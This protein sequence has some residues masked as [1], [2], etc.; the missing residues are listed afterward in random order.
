MG[1]ALGAITTSTSP[2]ATSLGAGVSS[3]GSEWSASATG[4]SASAGASASGVEPSC[5]AVS[6]GASA[7]ASCAGSSAGASASA[8]DA[9]TNSGVVAG[10]VAALPAPFLVMRATVRSR[11]WSR[12][13]WPLSRMVMEPLW[14]G[15]S[16]AVAA[17]QLMALAAAAR[18]REVMRALRYTFYSS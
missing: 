9:V 1:S 18:V 13:G 16:A 11:V 7:G 14:V 2:E 10:W 8:G 15:V 3:R 6:A 5:C 17:V 4:A 12:L